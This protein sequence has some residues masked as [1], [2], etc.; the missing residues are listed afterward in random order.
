VVEYNWF[1][2]TPFVIEEFNAIDD[3]FGHERVSGK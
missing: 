1:A 2:S 3:L